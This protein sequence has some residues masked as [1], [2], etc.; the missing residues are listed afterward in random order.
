MKAL[1]VISGRNLSVE[2]SEVE[3]QS[4]DLD[5]VTD[6]FENPQD[7]A[8]VTVKNVGNRMG[9]R[10]MIEVKFDE[11]T[12]TFINMDW[13]PH[14]LV[15]D[16][17]GEL[18]VDTLGAHDASSTTGVAVPKESFSTLF[19]SEETVEEVAPGTALAIP[20]MLIGLDFS[21]DQLRTMCIYVSRK[22]SVWGIGNVAW[23]MQEVAVE[24]SC[25]TV[26]HTDCEGHSITRSTIST[27]G[28]TWADL[29]FMADDLIKEAGNN[30]CTRIVGFYHLSPTHLVLVTDVLTI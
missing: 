19:L 9:D 22:N 29:N 3:L 4:F 28:I 23:R 25:V 8:L 18:L 15:E 26:E 24:A 2:F 30:R 21:T 20:E 16:G 12:W 7:M 10:P 5:G 17:I 13:Q 11:A 27:T 1:L 14:Q 6:Y